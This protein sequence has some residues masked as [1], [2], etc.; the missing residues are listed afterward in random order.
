V[1]IT[2]KFVYIHM[3]K[4]GGTFV[5]A[6]LHRV[7]NPDE[8]ASRRYDSVPWP[9]KSV[10]RR[11]QR[12][13]VNSVKR[14]GWVA[15]LDPKHGTCHEIPEPH[16]SKPILSTLRNPFDWYVSQYEFGWWKRTFLYHPESHPTPAGFAI[17]RILPDFIAT[18]SHFPDL[19]FPEFVELCDRASLVFNGEFG[20][21]LGLYTHSYL[22][23]YHRDVPA[24]ISHMDRD[25]ICSGRH[26][27]H[28]YNVH[29]MRT[30]RLNEELYDYLLLMGYR[31]EHLKFVPGLG[32]ILPMGLG[33]REDQKW[34]KYYTPSLKTH[35]RAK[36]WAVFEMFP[37]FDV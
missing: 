8:S 34:E 1:L 7:H 31:P 37:E 18:H 25:Y 15:D 29:F 20:T 19:S 33:R 5:T 2:E 22:R 3:P 6:V 35:I 14:Y 26:R 27:S 13:S 12:R 4:T 30:S 9:L 21:D 28:M 17:E 36:D 10:M 24:I 11:L 16:R 32:K 23:F